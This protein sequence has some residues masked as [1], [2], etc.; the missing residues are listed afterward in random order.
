MKPQTLGARTVGVPA[1]WQTAEAED[2][3]IR[4]SSPEGDVV[5]NAGALEAPMEG[6]LDDG[7]ADTRTKDALGALGATGVSSLSSAAASPGTVYCAKGS[8]GG[9]VVALCIY[10]TGSL[11]AGDPLAMVF[12]QGTSAGW[13][14]TGQALIVSILESMKGFEPIR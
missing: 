11:S 7:R 4:L 13:A 2:G 8:A 3:S 10:D 14:R 12:F 6:G 5:L 9:N 1:G